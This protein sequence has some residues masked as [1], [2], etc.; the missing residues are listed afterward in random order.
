[1]KR[2]LFFFAVCLPCLLAAQNINFE[3][4]DAAYFRYP[5]KPLDPSIKTYSPSVVQMDANLY[6]DQ[7][8]S[9]RRAIFIPGY[10]NLS[11]GGDVQVELIISPLT[12][13]NKEV[14]DLPMET[15]SNGKK[16]ITHQYWYELK[17]AFP[18]KIKM[19]QRGEALNDQDLPGFFTESYYPR[20]RNSQTILQQE[21]DRD[22]NFM[23]EISYKKIEE[24]KQQTRQW[25]FSNYGRGMVNEL[26][27]VGYVKDKKGE[28]AD[29]TKA[30][31]LLVR[32]FKSANNNREYFNDAFKESIN[33]AITIYSQALLESSEDKKARINE[34]VE[35]VIQYNLALAYYGLMKWDEADLWAGKVSKGTNVTI[36]YAH[37]LQER[38][39]DK[40][41]RVIAN[42]RVKTSSRGQKSS[43]MINPEVVSPA[44]AYRDY[45][46]NA[47]GDT[48]YAHL[49]VPS[50][51]IMPYGDSVWLQ[52]KVVIN[53]NNKRQ[54][55]L[56]EQ[57]H[58]YSYNGIVRESINWVKD[59]NTTPYTIEYKF[60]KRMASGTISVYDCYE[61]VP[62][63]RDPSVN[64]VIT[65]QWY[66]KGE[67]I[68]STGFLSFNKG[69]S[70]LVKEYPELS[71][72]V[73][74]GAYSREDFVKVVNEYNGRVK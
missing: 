22:A 17:L 32:A 66:K 62:S 29:L 60:C 73:R 67:L 21:F 37:R 16:I 47:S 46:V 59:F 43:V 39:E 24:M 31:S 55:F 33:E 26:I 28:Y 56:P 19:I 20:N 70:K 69:V 34:K 4:L 8:D 38:I 64:L 53:A 44:R 13:V 5:L 15:E 49:I 9:L 50:R 54:E 41:N 6:S 23:H 14:M 30:M 61:V 51:E 1:M 2:C 71:E 63:T 25:L 3:S 48:I 65:N 27:S 42:D 68:E 36:G 7:V 74:N 35:A 40:R 10:Q 12:V 72:K 58:S 57:L 11:A 45:I 52:D 18:A